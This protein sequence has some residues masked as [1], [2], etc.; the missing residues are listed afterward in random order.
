MKIAKFEDVNLIKL[1]EIKYENIK[2]IIDTTG[3]Y[4]RAFILNL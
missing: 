1:S 2:T 4:Q 3:I